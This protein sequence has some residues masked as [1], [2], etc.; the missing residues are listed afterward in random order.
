M[1]TLAA[2]LLVG[3]IMVVSGSAQ[4]AS[5]PANDTPEWL[6]PLQDLDREL[7]SWLRFNG[8]YRARLESSDHIK[9]GALNDVYLLSRLR[10]SISIRPS[11]WLEFAAETQDARAF[12]NHHVANTPPYQN[13]WDIRQAYV[14]LGSSKEGWVDAIGDVRLFSFGDERVIGPSNWLNQGRTFDAVRVDLHHPGFEVALFASSVVIARDGVV[15]HH[16]QGND[17][18]GVYGSIHSLIPKTT[19]EPYVL[20]RIAPANLKLA[21]NA[22]RGAL[23]EVTTGFRLA[24][25]LPWHFDENLEFEKQTGSLGPDSIH[26]WAGHANVGRTFESLKGKPRIFAEGNYAT[27]TKDPTSKTW[28]TFDQLYPSSHDKLGFA[29]QVG[30]RNI[31]QIRTG[32]EEKFNKR[33]RTKQTYENFWLVSARDALYASSG[34]LLLQSR[35]ER[36]AATWGK[37]ST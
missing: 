4:A 29:D 34:A 28:S 20:W 18:H 11:S 13:M 16:N 21:E 26:S 15:D 23:N 17:L 32:V 27:G 12:F 5:P 2:V 10:L 37:R 6:T 14:E 9:F 22:G 7:P 25:S 3:L 8:E 36:L 19:V 31:Q 24:G 1:K 33:W 30:Y 35:R